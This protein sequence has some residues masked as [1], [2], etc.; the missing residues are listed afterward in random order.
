MKQQ[1]IILLTINEGLAI[2]GVL[3]TGLML[4]TDR[5]GDANVIGA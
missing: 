1:R 5:N 2:S 3:P 4:T